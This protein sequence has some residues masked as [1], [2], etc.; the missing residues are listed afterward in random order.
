[1][2]IQRY[3]EFCSKNNTY[4]VRGLCMLLI[5]FHHIY[6]QM[7]QMGY[8]IPYVGILLS[9]G[10]F[11]GTGLFFFMSGYGL[12]HSMAFKEIIS[13]SYLWK[14]LLK[15]WSVFIVAYILAV[16][17]MVLNHE[18][19]FWGGLFGDFL[20]LTIPPT[21]T[22]FFKVIV[23]TYIVTF[24][25]FKLNVKREL[26]VGLVAL[27][28]VMY[29]VISSKLLPDFW[30]TSVLCFPIGMIV[31]LYKSNLNTKLQLLLSILF[32]PCFWEIKDLQWRF[33]TAILFCFFVLFLVRFVRYKSYVLRYIGT[34]SLC[35]YLF[36]LALLQNLHILTSHP[37]VYML[38]MVGCVFLFVFVYV[39]WLQPISNK[40]IN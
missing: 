37:L 21:T 10:G 32:V 1:M 11:L 22:W 26:K 18:I 7:I 33:I 16:I 34:N 30:Y 2:K 40:I 31:A 36:Q 27:G 8:S 17:P 23:L 38:L 35:F 4:E 12:Y 29:Y 9:P 3:T 5:L 39:K 19:F 15:M 28:Y 20:T 13:A 25:I 24:L 6:V 14:R